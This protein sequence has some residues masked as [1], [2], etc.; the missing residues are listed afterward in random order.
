M[1]SKSP[2]CL[3][4]PPTLSPAPP[5]ALATVSLRDADWLDI[6]IGSRSTAASSARRAAMTRLASTRPV[7]APL[8]LATT[9]PRGMAAM[10]VDRACIGNGE[11][12]WCLGERVY[13]VCREATRVGVQA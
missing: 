12:I 8:A 9:R 7:A 6:D 11:R 1:V 10:R 2:L 4:A 3:V 13:D 5:P